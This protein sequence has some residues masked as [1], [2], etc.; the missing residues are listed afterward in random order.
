M[1]KEPPEC[2]ILIVFF[3]V[4]P[5]VQPADPPPPAE[6]APVGGS[7]HRMVGRF[8]VT[9]AEQKEEQLTDSSPVSPDLERE[10]R[11]AKGKEGER[12]ERRTPV[13]GHHPP[14][15]HTHSP[16]G[17]SDDESEVEDEDLRRELHKLREK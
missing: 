13:P 7:V 2:S 15:S 11:K 16:V 17:S 12:E 3:Q 8:S 1:Q 14:R 5:V 10:R 6:T 9:Q 4:T